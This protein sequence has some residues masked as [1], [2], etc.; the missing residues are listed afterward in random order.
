MTIRHIFQKYG[1]DFT[2]KKNYYLLNYKKKK[3]NKQI[4]FVSFLNKNFIN[5]YKKKFYENTY[6]YIK[7]MKTLK[8]NV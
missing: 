7:F 1:K 6:S 2:I 5:T 8:N 3:L 4:L